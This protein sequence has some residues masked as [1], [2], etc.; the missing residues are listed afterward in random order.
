MGE[1]LVN[2]PAKLLAV[3]IGIV[4][5][6]FGTAC[7]TSSAGGS[8]S[9]HRNAA[10]VETLLSA[11]LMDNG[12]TTAGEAGRGKW[13]VTFPHGLTIT[14]HLTRAGRVT[15]VKHVPAAGA[16]ARLWKS[17]ERRLVHMNTSGLPFAT[18]PT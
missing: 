10:T 5:A 6:T 4:L 18:A 9:L 11:C 13:E 7:S 12:A 3:A 17:C 2:A 16:V 15:D 1:V 8:S 14:Y